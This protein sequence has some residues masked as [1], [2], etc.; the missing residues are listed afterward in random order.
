MK[1]K[2]LIIDDDHRNT[3][4]LTAVLK[5]RNYQVVSVASAP[6]GIHLLKNDKG[7]KI[8]LLDMMMPEMDGY[9]ALS[10][11]KEKEG[12]ADIPVIAVT[13]QAMTGDR[14]KCL[15]AGADGYISKPINTDQLLSILEGFNRNSDDQG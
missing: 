9:E 1:G 2:I 11:M 4:A 12:I 8:V 7:I 10:V 5:S 15:A 13:A 6:E 14:E 3:F